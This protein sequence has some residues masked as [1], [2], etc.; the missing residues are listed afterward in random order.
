MKN[1][2]LLTV[3]VV[4]LAG[5][6]LTLPLAKG[7]DKLVINEEAKEDVGPAPKVEDDKVAFYNQPDVVRAAEDEIVCPTKVILHYH[8]DDNKCLDRR[9]YTWVDGAEGV[10]DIV[11]LGKDRRTRLFPQPVKIIKVFFP[12]K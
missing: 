2:K 7:V 3:S 11:G 1:N 4:L 9:F 10:L 8:N 12:G 5:V 6:A